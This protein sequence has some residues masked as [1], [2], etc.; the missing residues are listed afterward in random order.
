MQ[1]VHLVPHY[2]YKSLHKRISKE[3]AVKHI[4]CRFS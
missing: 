4:Y 2:I 1:E 3:S